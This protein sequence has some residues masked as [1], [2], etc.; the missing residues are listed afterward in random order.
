[1]EEQTLLDCIAPAELDDIQKYK[2]RYEALAD[3]CFH[4]SKGSYRHVEVMERRRVKAE[5]CLIFYSLDNNG[6]LA[7]VGAL[8]LSGEVPRS[9]ALGFSGKRTGRISGQGENV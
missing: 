6:A 9:R 7:D 1:L 5:I 2:E 3:F 4:H 8:T